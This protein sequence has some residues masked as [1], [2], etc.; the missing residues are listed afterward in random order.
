MTECNQEC[1]QTGA[2]IFCDGQFLASGGDLQACADDLAAQFE[3]SI[4]VDVAVDVD[5]DVDGD[6]DDDADEDGVDLDGDGDSDVG[7]CSV[8]VDDPS[9]MGMAGAL[10]VFGLFGRRRRTQR[11]A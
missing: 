3:I 9:L 5:V 11:V 4:D 1:E 8:G 7:S 2:A 6:G 10:F